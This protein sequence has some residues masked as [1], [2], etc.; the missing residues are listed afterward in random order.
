[1][2]KNAR[3]P[4]RILPAVLLVLLLVL[5][6]CGQR[7]NIVGTWR[8]R[9]DMK[10]MLNEGLKASGVQLTTSIPA[11]YILVLKEDRTFTFDIDPE[12]FRNGFSEAF[13]RDGEA[14][15]Y[16][17]LK[18]SGIAED[19]YDWI[20]ESSGFENF[21]EF[22]RDMIDRMVEEATETAMNGLGAAHIDGTYAYTGTDIHLISRGED[23]STSADD[24]VLTDEGMI[25]LVSKDESLPMDLLFRK[26]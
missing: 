25:S 16:A 19:K 9:Y 21:D 12:T 2:M 22:E 6:G 17:A 5:P 15:I 11:D 20:I 7:M 4:I 18:A 1:M 24:A 10:D 14:I 23:G 26:D 3:K 8:A 13:H